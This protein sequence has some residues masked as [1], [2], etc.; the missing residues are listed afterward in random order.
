MKKKYYFKNY[1]YIL[2]FVITLLM[3]NAITNFTIDNIFLDLLAKGFISVILSLLI[4]FIVLMLNDEFKYGVISIFKMLKEYLSNKS[5][6]S[7]I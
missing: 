5:K 3:F 1:S 7:E 4:S 2:I 6:K